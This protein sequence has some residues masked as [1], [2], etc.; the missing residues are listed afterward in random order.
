MTIKSKLANE[1]SHLLFENKLVRKVK[2]TSREFS[3]SPRHA[4]RIDSGKLFENLPELIK[5]TAAAAILGISVKTIYDWRYR[6]K[7]RKIPDGFFVKVNRSLL[8]RTKI[9]K[10]WIA[11]QNPSLSEGG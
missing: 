5:P 9:L 2:D 4:Q 7:Q 6:L 11:S 3:N 10:Q 1:N 8:I